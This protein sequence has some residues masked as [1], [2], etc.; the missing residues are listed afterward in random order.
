M[1]KICYYK[2]VVFAVVLMAN[3]GF[4]PFGRSQLIQ[5][6][7]PPTPIQ[8]CSDPLP[9]DTQLPSGILTTSEIQ[10]WLRNVES[11]LNEICSLVSKSK[12]N[13]EQKLRVQNLCRKATG[14]MSQMAILYQSLKQ[15]TMQAY[16]TV[17]L[18]PTI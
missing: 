6:S 14:G 1:N 12:M 4:R 9:M 17:K 18:P 8:S 2:Q 5:R 3:P 10:K 13:S 16:T 15:K 7:P 11:V